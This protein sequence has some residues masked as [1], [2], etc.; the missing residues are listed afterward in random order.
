MQ[1][2]LARSEL[3]IRLA[4]AARIRDACTHP[5][6]INPMFPAARFYQM[7]GYSPV[8]VDRHGL[9]PQGQTLLTAL[10]A[11]ADD[12]LDPDEYLLPSLRASLKHSMAF[13]DAILLDDP[14]R[15]I[16]FDVALT[17][18]V[19]R[20]IQHLSQGR[21]AP[22]SV[23]RQWF[24]QPRASTEDIPAEL[25][26]ALNQ[27]RLKAYIESLHPKGDAYRGLRKALQ[28]YEQI[29]RSG[30]W[31]AI[32]PGP[33]L[34][35][36]D[37][38]LR[39]EALKRRL[40]MTHDLSADMPVDPSRYDE[41]VK[42][43]VKRFQR[44]HGL[45]ADG[46]VGNQTRAAMN[47]SV[48]ERI[49]QMQLNMERWRWFPDNFGDRYVM[50]NIPA[51]ELRVIEAGKHIDSMRAIV[52]RKQR[53]TPV[54]S[55]RMTYLELNPYWNIP[56]KI[57]RRDILPKVVGDPAYLHRQG[58]RIFDGW[59]HQAREL[60]PAG[61]TW[62]NLSA[63]YFPYRLRQDPSEVNA[64]GRVK[65]MFPNTQSVYIH[66]TPSRSLFNRQE[67]SLS[68]GCV[69]VESPLALAQYLL[70]NQGWDR[71]RLETAV[72]NGQ[73]Q[74]VVLD[75]PIPVH[76]VY[77]TTWVDGDGTVQFRE[78]IYGKDQLHQAAISQRAADLIFCS[79]DAEKGHLLAAG[80][81]VDKAVQ[82]TSGGPIH[83][84]PSA[85]ETAL[86]LAGNPMAGL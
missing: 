49:T 70:N 31:P 38:G 43:A 7:V 37:T 66:D 55:G 8:W 79:D 40:R 51:F 22:E 12:G 74:A 45:E 21:L 54:M 86:K 4:E 72:A 82:S 6:G 53:Q 71:S 65:F 68:S 56:P 14:I 42:S 16:R 77:F 48:E 75:N 25:A 47:V 35:E 27:N 58:I 84:N 39:V 62:E 18:G 2:W 11:S 17:D 10:A 69:R 34:Q 24:A 50:V 52:G 29:K 60:D 19:L 59:D 83:I 20:Y 73:R 30:G 85:I 44:R 81:A 57:A 46:L 15:C 64:L 26:R 5:P 76:L 3:Q 78:D 80:A 36:G 13:S 61:I 28:H 33:T 23:A 9:R 1:P 32:P 41:I 63:R 67:R